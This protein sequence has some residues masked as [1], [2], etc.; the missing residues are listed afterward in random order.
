VLCVHVRGILVRD[1]NSVNIKPRRV[2]PNN[3]V[4]AEWEE[5]GIPTVYR[6]RD[7]GIPT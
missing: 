5:L 1:I 2:M 4:P 6:N 7:C 3:Q